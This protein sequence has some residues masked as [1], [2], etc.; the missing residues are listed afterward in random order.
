MVL[1][2]MIASGELSALALPGAGPAARRSVHLKGSP[3]SEG[4]ALGHVVLHEPR[5]V[6]TNFIAEDVQKEVVRLRS[7][8]ESLRTNL[9]QMLEHGDVVEGG[10]HRDVLEAYRMFAYDRGWA[11]KL[12][13]AVLTGL[14]AEAAVERVQS[15]T[16]A[17]ML[18]ATDPYLRERLHDL[19]ELANRLM[20]QLLGQDYA[21]GR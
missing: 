17:R 8:V 10:E 19:D 3:L 21:P 12:E 13:E 20:H 5:V 16:R 2:E 14:T 11:H 7:A 6:V 1:A 9:D 15:D 18:R 4:I